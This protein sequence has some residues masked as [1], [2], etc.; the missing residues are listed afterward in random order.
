[1]V[2]FRTYS[3]KDSIFI[4]RGCGMGEKEEE[5]KTSPRFETWVTRMELP[6]S[7]VGDAHERGDE[8]CLDTVP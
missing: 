4:W 7:L 8:L 3:E 5:S 2:G 6:L 1:M